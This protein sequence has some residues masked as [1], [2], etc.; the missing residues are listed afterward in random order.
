MVVYT[1]HGLAFAIVLEPLPLGHL[2]TR[3]FHLHLP[4]LIPSICPSIERALRKASHLERS[5]TAMTC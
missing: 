2:W 3:F 1:L 4:L 5:C